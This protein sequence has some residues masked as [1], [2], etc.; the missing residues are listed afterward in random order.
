M[1]LTKKMS[2]LCSSCC[3]NY[4]KKNV[5]L[6]HLLRMPHANTFGSFDYQFGIHQDN[7]YTMFDWVCGRFS[8]Y[9]SAAG[10]VSTKHTTISQS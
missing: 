5:L 2:V 4:T 9:W 7:I 1:G 3:V 8:L 10:M 6:H